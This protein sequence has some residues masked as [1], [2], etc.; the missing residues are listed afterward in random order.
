MIKLNDLNQLLKN[1]QLINYI[2]IIQLLKNSYLKILIIYWLI[3]QLKIK[4]ILFLLFILLNLLKIVL[5]IIL[6]YVDF[7][8]LLIKLVH[9]HQNYNHLIIII[10]IF[11][12]AKLVNGPLL[13]LKKN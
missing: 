5:I 1:H 2:L 3:H 8:I 7:L 6:N 11:S 13:I 10:L 4:N 9:Y 12:L